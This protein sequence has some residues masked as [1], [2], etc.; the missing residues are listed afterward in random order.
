MELRRLEYFVAVVEEANFT[1]AADRMH[2]AQSGLSAQI[3]KLEGDLGAVLLDRSARAVV[4]TEAGRAVLPYARA[5]LQAYSDARQAVAELT[6]LVRGHLRLGV[7]ASVSAFD[8]PQL[9]ADFHRAHPGVEITLSENGP[10]LALELLR[11]GR[12]DLTLVGLGPALP[13]GVVV[14][15]VADEPVVAVVAATEPE[16]AATLAALAERDLICLPPGGGL[17]AEFDSA[18]ARAGFAPRVVFE[19]GD[20]HMLARLAG[21]GL[22]VAILPLSVARRHPDVRATPIEGLSL[23]ARIGLAHRGEPTVSPAARA[24]LRHIR[25]ALQSAYSGDA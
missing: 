22:G 24:F 25:N 11:S 23:R 21:C 10:E 15:I 3:R 14:E 6:G 2:V 20:P 17:R 1:R 8:L 16:G 7:T 4:P 12:L 19:A 13:D 18:C 9:L 5:A